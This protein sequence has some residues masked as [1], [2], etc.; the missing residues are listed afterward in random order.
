MMLDPLLP[1]VLP[2]PVSIAE[3]DLPLAEFDELRS[4]AWCSSARIGGGV[5]GGV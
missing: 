5:G 2:T 1:L 4:R 3:Y